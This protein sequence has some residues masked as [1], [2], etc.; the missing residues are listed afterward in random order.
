MCQDL[1]R[2]QA[3]IEKSRF[4]KISTEKKKAGLDCRENLD[5]LKKLV[6]TDRDVLI[7]ILIALDC[8]DPQA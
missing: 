3:L 1:E 2:S 8:R 6:S 5:T 4:L 7:S